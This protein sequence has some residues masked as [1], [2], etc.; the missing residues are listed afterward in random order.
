MNNKDWGK[1]FEQTTAKKQDYFLIEDVP[2]SKDTR[3]KDF[4]DRSK[5]KLNDFGTSENTFYLNYSC[6]D[7]DIDYLLTSHGGHTIWS[8][9]GGGH[10][11]LKDYVDTENDNLFDYIYIKESDDS[12]FL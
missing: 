10:I 6:S 1:G 11:M 3:I 8:Y 7:R 4:F 2:F 5:F 9:S 12:D